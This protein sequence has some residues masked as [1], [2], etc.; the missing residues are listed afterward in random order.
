MDEV[1][2]IQLGRRNAID[3]GNMQQLCQSL[4]TAQDPGSVVYAPCAR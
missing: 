2:C 1:S 4:I 3:K